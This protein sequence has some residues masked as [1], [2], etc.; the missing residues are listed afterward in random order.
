MAPCS[1]SRNFPDIALLSSAA[2]NNAARRR[3]KEDDEEEVVAAIEAAVAGAGAESE[4]HRGR[5]PPPREL[6]RGSRPQGNQRSLLKAPAPVLDREVSGRR[7]ERG[8]R[9]V[10][11][12][13]ASR[14]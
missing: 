14:D 3:R 13:E 2:E 7:G 4:E 8:R 12:E 5:A 1:P 9:Q 6:P 10:K 11:R